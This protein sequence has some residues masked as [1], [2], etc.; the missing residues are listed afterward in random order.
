[1]I[2][3]MC[4]EVMTGGEPGLSTGVAYEEPEHDQTEGDAE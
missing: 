3:Q 4:F 1:M 2:L